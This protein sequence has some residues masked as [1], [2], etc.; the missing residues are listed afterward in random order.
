VE[1]PLL[2]SPSGISRLVDRLKSEGLIVRGPDSDD[3]RATTVT[4]TAAGWDRLEAV[5]A[6]HVAG[7]RRYFL[8]QAR[9]GDLRALVELWRRILDAGAP[10]AP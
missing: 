1:E 6:T 5:H 7:V 10:R 8:A 3:N 4:L 2:L 9:P